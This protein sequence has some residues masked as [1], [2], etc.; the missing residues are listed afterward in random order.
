MR[1]VLPVVPADPT[2]TQATCAAGE[3]TVPTMALATESGGGHLCRWIRRVRMTRGP[4]DYTVTVTAT[5]SDGLEWGTIAAGVDVCRPDDGDVHA[6]TLNGDVVCRGDAGGADGDAGGVSWWGVGAADVDVGRRP[7]G[8][9]TRVDT[10][11]RRMCRAELV[12]VT[13][14]FDDDRGGLARSSCRRGGPRR[15]S[16]TATYTVTFADAACT[17]VVPVDPTVTQATCTNGEVTVPTVAPATE[18]G[19]GHLRVGSAGSV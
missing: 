15:R 9:P 5:L 2:V 4:S 16:T 13:A 10:R 1:R 11:S 14:T 6:S 18:S 3:V 17:P 19:G 12:T 8:S 7:T